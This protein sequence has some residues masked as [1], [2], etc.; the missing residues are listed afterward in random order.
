MG[1]GGAA[2]FIIIRLADDERVV[3]DLDGDEA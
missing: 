3:E 1:S 2:N